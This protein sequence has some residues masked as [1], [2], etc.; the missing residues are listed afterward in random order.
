MRIRRTLFLLFAVA[1]SSAAAPQSASNRILSDLLI[2]NGR[3]MDGSGNPWFYGDV[4]VKDGKIAAIGR[5][6]QEDL[7][8]VLADPQKVSALKGDIRCA[9]DRGVL[10]V[11]NVVRSMTSLPAQ[12]P[13]LRD[14]GMIREGLAADLVVFDPAKIRDTATFFEPH[15]Y[16]EGIEYVLVNGRFVV[17]GGR[18]T[19]ERPGM[20]VTR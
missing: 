12:I 9:M 1:L 16:A 15:K 5:N 10:T 4:A 6:P 2:L 20:V 18:L 7:K 8:K 3:I 19:W 13:G 14:R 11:E 17:D